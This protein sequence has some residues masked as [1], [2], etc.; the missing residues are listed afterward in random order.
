M[1]GA[2]GYTWDIFAHELDP[3]GNSYSFG[4]ESQDFS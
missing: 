1:L 4:F 3:Q 2:V